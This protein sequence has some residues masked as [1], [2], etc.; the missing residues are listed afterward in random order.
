LL[1]SAQLSSSQ[2]AS[3]EKNWVNQFIKHHKE[4]CSKYSQK[5]DYQ[6]AQCKDPELIKGW[7]A[8]FYNA[9]QKYGILEQDIYNIDK[10]DFQMG[11]ISTAKVVCSSETR[12]S[13]AKII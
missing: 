3:I 9:I 5:Y 4:L 13:H 10:T 11:V 7:F 12:E 1:L 2:E 8:Q 6:Q